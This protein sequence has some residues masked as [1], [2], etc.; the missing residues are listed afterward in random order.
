[1]G[2]CNSPNIFQENISKIF[3]EFNIVHAYID[4]VLVIKKHEFVYHLKAP[5]YFIETRGSGI[6]SKNVKFI[7][8]MHRN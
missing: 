1:M 5:E 2:I 6:K 7:T 8:R 3:E 4:N